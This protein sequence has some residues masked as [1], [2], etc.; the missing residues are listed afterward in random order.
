MEEVPIGAAMVLSAASVMRRWQK[1]FGA[2]LGIL[3]LLKID[4]LPWILLVFITAVIVWR[5]IPGKALAIAL[6]IS[7][8][9]ILWSTFYFGSPIP[10]TIFAK[11]LAYPSLTTSLID[12][13]IA[14]P[15]PGSIQTYLLPKLAFALCAYGLIIATAIRSFRRK[16]WIF[17]VFPCF[18]LTYTLLLAFSG[19]DLGLSVRWTVPLWITLLIGAAYLAEGGARLLPNSFAE[20]WLS[21]LL[22]FIFVIALVVPIVYEN[23]KALDSSSFRE[24]G[25]WLQM[26]AKPGESMMLEPIGLIGYQTGLYVYDFIGLVSPEVTE[27]RTA[28][29][30]SDSWYMNYVR[31]HRPTYVILRAEEI[32][33]NRFTYGGYGGKVFSDS[34]SLWFKANYETVFAMTGGP[35]VDRLVVHRVRLH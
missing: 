20:K 10:H 24:T 21:A 35:T 18:G 19:V 17:L 28:S 30:R 14:I 4:T 13:F 8:P 22:I 34:D 31:A 26:H 6:L 23:R 2:S 29:G 33:G 12:D 27:A 9:W 5:E 3:F 1:V 25:H 16:D 7:L 32:Q 15:S 11:R